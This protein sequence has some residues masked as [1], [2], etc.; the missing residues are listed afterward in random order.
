MNYINI[1]SKM[2][3][4]ILLSIVLLSALHTFAQEGSA[5]PYSFY[6]IGELKFK[7]NIETRAMG[8]LGIVADSI[9]SNLSNPASISYLKLTTFSVAGTFSPERMKTDSQTE[10][11]QRTFLDYL[12]A[13]FPGGKYAFNM[14]LMPYTAVGYNILTNQTGGS[15]LSTG[16]GGVNKAFVGASYKI[17]K[18]FSIGADFAYN[19]GKIENKSIYAYED[20]QFNNREVNT[21]RINGVSF[22][23]GGIYETKLGKYTITSSLVVSPQASLT[24]TN[25]RTTS[26]III[27]ASGTETVFDQ[28]V[29]TVPNSKIKLPT[30]VAFGGGIGELK[31]WFVGFETAFQGTPS[32][33]TAYNSNVSFENGSRVS[34]GGYYIP[35]YNSFSNYFNRVTYRAGFRHENTGLVINSQS[36]NDTS[37]S[38]GMGLPVGG[39]FS[40]INLGFDLGKRGTTKAGLIQENYMNFSVGL[41]F[42]DKW[43]V[44][45]KYD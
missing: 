23:L 26:K 10:K 5:S 35:K 28:I 29:T 39:A 9:H 11:A 4:K 6:G 15:V 8:G 32:Y 13:S 18:N 3:K 34:L 22:N 19:F 33:G 24:S 17:N 43:F 44:K 16:K 12:T 45:R 36:I 30:K 25:E 27:N 7:G 21:S 41:S 40:N 38:L 37:F 31:K 1:K 14:G 20:I 42:N 2:I